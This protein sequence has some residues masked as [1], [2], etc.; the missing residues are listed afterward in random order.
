MHNKGLS[1]SNVNINY[2]ALILLFRQV[3]GLEWD[4]QMIPRPKL[5]KELPII[6]SHQEVE[7]LINGIKNL[8]H[9]TIVITLYSTGCR[10]SELLNLKI[11]DI[12]INGLMV[13]VNKGKGSKDRIIHVSKKFIG[14]LGGYQMKY[15]PSDY[16]F[17]GAGSNR[18]ISIRY[19]ASSVR[20]IINNAAAGSGITKD[21]SPHI[22]RHSYATHNLDFGT[23]LEYLRQQLGHRSL[24]TTSK[25]LHLCRYQSQRVF[26][27]IDQLQIR[28][29]GAII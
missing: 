21:V 15:A 27:P 16:V 2:S 1:W 14:I 7:R 3:L 19:S 12:D 8:K 13:R 6:L 29:L 25:Y 10:I 11:N 9:Q 28:V 20:K 23:N 24:K 17:E 22:F 26:H 4:Y 5:S 18:D